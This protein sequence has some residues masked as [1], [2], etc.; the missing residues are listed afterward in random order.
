[1]DETTAVVTSTAL[2]PASLD[3][4]REVGIVVRDPAN[5]ARLKQF[6]DTMVHRRPEGLT[7]LAEFADADPWGAD[8]LDD[9]LD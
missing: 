6:F 7:R 9:E 3:E 2:T 4:R 1:V 5:T 8:D